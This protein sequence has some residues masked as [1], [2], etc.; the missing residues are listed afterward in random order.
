VRERQFGFQCVC[1]VHDADPV[2]CSGERIGELDNDFGCDGELVCG[3]RCELVHGSAQ[4]D[5]LKH[6]DDD[7]GCNDN[8]PGIDRSI[9]VYGS[10]GSGVCG[11]R[12]RQFGFQ[13]VCDVH[14]AGSLF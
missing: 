9:C 14:D 2:R 10:R 6:V 4:A 5:G 12:E 1:D 7:Y 8:E 13:C 3:E 11:V